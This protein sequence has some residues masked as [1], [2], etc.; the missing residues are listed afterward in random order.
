MPKAQN[1]SVEAILADLMTTSTMRIF[2]EFMVKWKGPGY[3]EISWECEA[4]SL[5]LS[6]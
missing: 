5:I 4:K 2:K 6:I 1:S 3:D